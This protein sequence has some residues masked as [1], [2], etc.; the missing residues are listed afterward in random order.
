MKLFLEKDIKKMVKY[1][2]FKSS[3]IYKSKGLYRVYFVDSNNAK[4]S[5]LKFNSDNKTRSFKNIESACN[6]LFS[7]QIN[8]FEVIDKDLLSC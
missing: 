3:F 2:F 4:Y 5:I 7:M 6:K 1:N 8:R